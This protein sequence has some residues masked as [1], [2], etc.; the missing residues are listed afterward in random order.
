MENDTHEQN[1][2]HRYT[3]I[4]D[5]LDRCGLHLSQPSLSGAQKAVLFQVACHVSDLPQPSD[6]LA[7]DMC[8]EPALLVRGADGEV[9]AFYDKKRNK[10]S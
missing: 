7:F 2:P 4:P 8:R 10:P 3:S 1:M 9:R 5:D 6:Y